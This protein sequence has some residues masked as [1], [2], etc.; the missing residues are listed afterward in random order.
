MFLVSRSLRQRISRVVQRLW[1]FGLVY[2]LVALLQLC[3]FSLDLG[4]IESAHMDSKWL[5]EDS[6]KD[7]NTIIKI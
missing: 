6:L 4:C 3:I 5:L 7:N 2:S 1:L